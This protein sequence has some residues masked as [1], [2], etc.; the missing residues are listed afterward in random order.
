VE[1]LDI[2]EGDEVFAVIKS[3]EVLIG[4][5]AMKKE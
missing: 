1:K 4:K 2:K 3:T 5:T